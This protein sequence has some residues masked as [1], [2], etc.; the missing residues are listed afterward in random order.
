MTYEVGP[1][2]RVN[3]GGGPFQAAGS[4]ARGGSELH[5]VGTTPGNR[6][7]DLIRGQLR[8]VEDDGTAQLESIKELLDRLA[9]RNGLVP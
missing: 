6:D 1:D 4:L 5:Y 3:L 8:S 2:C 9:V 7:G